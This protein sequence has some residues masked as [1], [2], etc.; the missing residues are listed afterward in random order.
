PTPPPTLP[1]PSE[2]DDEEPG[3]GGLFAPAPPRPKIWAGGAD[4]GLSG[5]TGN[6]ELLNLR[7]GWNVRRKTERN[8][9]TSDLQYVYSQQDR[10]T[11]AH[12][13]LFNTRDEVLFPSTRWSAFTAG[14]LEYDLLRAYRFRCR[15]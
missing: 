12:Q 7:G 9:F 5:A 8:V 13:A 1:P 11:K 14:Q 10:A 15:T 4:L 2:D 6:S 3:P